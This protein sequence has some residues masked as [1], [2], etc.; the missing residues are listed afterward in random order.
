MEV[1]LSFPE[2]GAPRTLVVLVAHFKAMANVDGYT[3]RTRPR[4]R[5]RSTST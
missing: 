4:P 5:S 2:D 3:R 1:K